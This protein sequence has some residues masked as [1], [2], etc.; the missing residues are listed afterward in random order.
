MISHF[1]A[2]SVFVAV[3]QTPHYVAVE[4]LDRQR[5]LQRAVIQHWFITLAPRSPA[6]LFEVLVVAQRYPPR[7][8]TMIPF[9]P[10]DGFDLRDQF[11]L[12]PKAFGIFSSVSPSPRTACRVAA[13]L[14]QRPVRDRR[15]VAANRNTPITWLDPLRRRRARARRRE[16][17]PLQRRIA[18]G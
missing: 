18:D 15:T 5:S 10:L 14:H 17:L 1:R 7:V 11:G 16:S 3:F 2:S 8:T 9:G 6:Y 12:E 13:N 4:D